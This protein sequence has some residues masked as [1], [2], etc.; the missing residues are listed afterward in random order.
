VLY[1]LFFFFFF[2]FL[3]LLLV[4]GCFSLKMRAKCKWRLWGKMEKKER[5]KRLHSFIFRLRVSLCFR[6]NANAEI[7]ATQTEREREREKEGS[8]TPVV[9]FAGSYAKHAPFVYVKVTAKR[10]RDRVFEFGKEEEVI[11]R[12]NTKRWRRKSSA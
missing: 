9:V 11:R 5:K 12:K 10:E 4:P 1:S 7:R 2:F 8:R 6:T 3:L